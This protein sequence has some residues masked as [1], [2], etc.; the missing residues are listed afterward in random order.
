M[1][2]IKT[3][4]YSVSDTERLVSAYESCDTDKERKETVVRFADALGKTTNAIIAKLSSMKVYVKPVKV[5]KS[6][7][8]IVR[9]ATIVNSIA[10]AL[11]MDAEVLESLEK[12]TKKALE[13]VL[14]G[15]EAKS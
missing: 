7:T 1:T 6:G 13:A 2:T 10:D 14:A 4:N 9:K 3:P 15:L 8:A 12:A 11:E 5:T